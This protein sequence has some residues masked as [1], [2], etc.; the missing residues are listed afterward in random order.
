MRGAGKKKEVKLG[1]MGRHQQQ[2]LPLPHRK[3]RGRLVAILG[4][5]TSNWHTAA[6]PNLRMSAAAALGCGAGVNPHILYGE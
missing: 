1:Q 5:G 6:W 4:G 3:T 2:G